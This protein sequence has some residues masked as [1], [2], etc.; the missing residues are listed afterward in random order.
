MYK[1]CR[2]CNND[3]NLTWLSVKERQFNNGE[4]FNYFICNKCKAMQ[5]ADEIE[6]IGDYYGPN[7]YSYNI[8]SKRLFFPKFVV[9]PLMWLAYHGIPKTRLFRGVFSSLFQLS[10][11]LYG[12]QKGFDSNI[13]DVG[14][15]NG[16]HASVLKK[17][18]YKETACADPFCEK[19]GFNNICFYKSDIT[20]IESEKKY[21]V[22]VMSSSFEHMDNPHE[23]LESVNNLLNDDGVCLIKIPTWDSL[24]YRKY[25]ENWY[26]LDAPR[27]IF[28]YQEES[29]DYLC[30]SHN[31][32]IIKKQRFSG[33]KQIYI[34]E[35][36]KKTELSFKQCIDKYNN[37]SLL[38]KLRYEIMAVELDN[39]NKGDV[40]WFYIQ[41]D[42]E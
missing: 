21:D 6:N 7:Y 37:L 1:R 15:G 25:K 34:S 30:K 19:P 26:Q 11:G 3:D 32:K 31:L 42:K 17:Y 41:K 23:V 18:G 12:I 20:E 22:I 38:K 29:L 33:N 35:L 4:I 39:A 36:Y 16:F 14:G 5:L 2:I 9:Q 28:L 40:I 10:Y 27:H 13:L 8:R 24:A